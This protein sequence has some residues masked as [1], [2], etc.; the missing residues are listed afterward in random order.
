MSAGA[1]P[2]QA[3][4]DAAAR[5]TSPPEHQKRQRHANGRRKSNAGLQ[6]PTFITGS[7]Q[8]NNASAGASAGAPH[9]RRDRRRRTRPG[10]D[11]RR[12]SVTGAQGNLARPRFGITKAH[13]ENFNKQLDRDEPRPFF[14]KSL[15]ATGSINLAE[16]AQVGGDDLIGYP[17]GNI[18][19]DTRSFMLSLS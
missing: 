9:G 13:V 12:R 7:G 8:G 11:G 16:L 6:G 15:M 10:K 5:P 19:G 18:P 14:V 17:D 3:A 2:A 4:A 1:A